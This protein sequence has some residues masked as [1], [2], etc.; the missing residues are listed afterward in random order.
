M[1]KDIIDVVKNVDGQQSNLDNTIS[2]DTSQI[3]RLLGL[4]SRWWAVPTGYT[5]KLGY[6]KTKIVGV[7]KTNGGYPLSESSVTNHDAY[8]KLRVQ[9]EAEN[10]IKPVSIILDT[11]P[12]VDDAVALLYALRSSKLRLQAITL[13][14]GNTHIE[15]CK[16]NI[17]TIVSVICRDAGHNRDAFMSLRK[18]SLGNPI[19]NVACGDGKPLVG[20]PHYGHY[21]HGMD[22]LG[23][24]R[25]EFYPIKRENMDEENEKTKESN[26]NINECTNII[27]YSSKLA[28]DEILHI[29]EKEPE[30]SVIICAVGPL[31]NVAK[32]IRK[33][34]EIMKRCRAVFVMGG[35]IHIPGNV[36]QSAEF[37]FHADALAAYEVLHAAV[38]KEDLESY[39]AETT[40][41]ER[42][43]EELKKIKASID[44]ANDDNHKKSEFNENKLYHN[45]VDVVLFSLDSTTSVGT[46]NSRILL[47]GMEKFANKE[48][49]LSRT[50][51]SNDISHHSGL[52]ALFISSIMKRSGLLYRTKMLEEIAQLKS[53]SDDPSL[54]N[55]PTEVFLNM[56]DPLT[57]VAAAMGSGIVRCDSE[58]LVVEPVAKFTKGSCTLDFRD[59]P[60]IKT[61]FSLRQKF[62][63][64]KDSIINENATKDTKKHTGI[65]I[66]TSGDTQEFIKEFILT[67]VGCRDINILLK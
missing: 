25:D 50:K 23:G 45:I 57:V 5:N 43:Q 51:L 56:H 64:F 59:T 8:D 38:D 67:A 21:F 26:H 2:E 47:E 65:Y 54:I 22:G 41:I 60:R 40:E 55:E 34:P 11:D 19:L 37:N 20:V 3:D 61:L 48:L 28:E 39:H 10:K 30:D 16:I 4:H 62:L 36:T 52:S 32:A 63:K 14:Q 18:D 27:H 6:H 17:E 42:E 49:Q 53:Q 58:I 12:G 33:D 1:T 66:C 31:T 29:L 13:T 46:I 7:D 44:N 24:C 15:N 35:N 9:L